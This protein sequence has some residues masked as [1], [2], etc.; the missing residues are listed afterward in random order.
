MRKHFL[1]F[2]CWLVISFMASCGGNNLFSSSKKN[3][4]EVATKALEKSEPDKAISTLLSALGDSFRAIYET[5]DASSDLTV[6]QDLLHTEI[7]RL[8][9]LGSVEDANNLVSILASAQAQ[10]GGIDP[11]SIILYMAKSETSTALLATQNEAIKLFPALPDASLDN[12]RNL[13]FAI[14]LLNAIGEDY[15]INADHF[16]IAIFGTAY[17]ALTIKHLDTDGDGNI[18]ITEALQVGESLAVDLISI[19]AQASASI[20]ATQAQEDDARAKASAQN[21]SD[22][23]SKIDA[24]PGTTNAEKL[25]NFISSSTN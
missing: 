10:K 5:V 17:F 24:S 11:L 16:K 14:T 7:Q 12:L 4:A 8:I 13:Q 20:G 18:S 15:F 3:A 6:I 22:I 25:Q 21:I 2:S 23:Q 19:I 9:A 1:Q